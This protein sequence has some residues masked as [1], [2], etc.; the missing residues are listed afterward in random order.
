M[1]GEMRA[2]QPASCW[3]AARTK[4]RQEKTS[5]AMLQSMAVEHYL[6]LQTEA[7][8]WSDR[9]QTITVPLFAGYVFVR[10][11]LTGPERA[12]ILRLPGIVGMVANKDGPCPIPDREIDQ[13]RTALASGTQYAV[14]PLLRVGYRV[15]V[16]RG[17]LQGLEGIM[18]RT[19]SSCR[20]IMSVTMIQQ[21]VAIDVGL[22]DVEP[23]LGEALCSTVRSHANS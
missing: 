14:V 8:Q 19:T 1:T 15:R 16:V 5:A 21:S 7:R 12:M 2:P 9:K 4:S 6:P 13:V 18:I 11:D 17:A 23:V 22:T 3:F 10:L 20:L